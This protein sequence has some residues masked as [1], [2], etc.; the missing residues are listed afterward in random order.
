MYLFSLIKKSISFCSIVVLL[1]Y[2]P[3]QHS[4][5]RLDLDESIATILRAAIDG[6]VHETVGKLFSVER[7]CGYVD[8]AGSGAIANVPACLPLGRVGPE[9]SQQGWF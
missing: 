6:D 1:A 5:L 2:S 4:L 9:T 3:R 8:C 7:S